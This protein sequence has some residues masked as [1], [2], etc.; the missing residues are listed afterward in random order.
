MKILNRLVMPVLLTT[1]LLGLPSTL[2]GSVSSRQTTYTSGV[3]ELSEANTSGIDNIIP[4]D[5]NNHGVPLLDAEIEDTGIPL[6]DPNDN[7]SG[8][9]YPANGSSFEYPANK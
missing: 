9:V 2:Q 1:L 7:G 6:L 5:S 3:T 8:F 4:M